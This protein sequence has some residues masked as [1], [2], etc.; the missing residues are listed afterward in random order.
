MALEGLMPSPPS[1]ARWL[2]SPQREAPGDA[3]GRRT[4]APSRDAAR[5]LP[6]LERRSKRKET[7]V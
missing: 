3:D 7:T 4:P 6:R 5:L 1:L 2:V